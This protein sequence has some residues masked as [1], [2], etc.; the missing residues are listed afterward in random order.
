MKKFKI[1]SFYKFTPISRPKKIKLSLDNYISDKT[2][3][4][5]ILLANE[6]INGSLASSIE[7]IEYD[8]ESNQ[9]IKLPKMDV[10]FHFGGQ[11]SSKLSQSEIIK[12]SNINIGGFLRILESLQKENQKTFVV[13]LGTSTQ[14]GY[15]EY[16]E[17]KKNT[18]PPP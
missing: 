11:T 10:L 14:I 4:G 12:D 5:T 7:N 13:S 1:V 6:G 15:T 8:L 18:G 2:L 17:T 9:C 16:S 3:R